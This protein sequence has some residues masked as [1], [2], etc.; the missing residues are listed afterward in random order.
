MSALR[1]GP[2]LCVYLPAAIT[3]VLGFIS[4][5]VAYLPAPV[6]YSPTPVVY[7]PAAMIAVGVSYPFT[8]ELKSVTGRHNNKLGPGAGIAAYI[9]SIMASFMKL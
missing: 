4:Q 7:W 5:V 8:Q 3:S 1:L 9:S 2:A 6:A